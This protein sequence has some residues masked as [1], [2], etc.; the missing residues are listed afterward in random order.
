MDANYYIFIFSYQRR[1]KDVNPD[2]P[3]IHTMI[4]SDAENVKEMILNQ[5]RHRE[6][7]Q[8]NE[9]GDELNSSIH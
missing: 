3:L 8:T 9:C 7:N 6:K 4:Q 1:K 2:H 5:R